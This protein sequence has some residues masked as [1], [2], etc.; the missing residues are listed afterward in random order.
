MAS[1]LSCALLLAALCWVG[2]AQQ[3]VATNPCDFDNG[4]TWVSC[5]EEAI[6]R[7]KASLSDRI[8]ASEKLQDLQVACSKY[9]LTDIHLIGA[10]EFEVIRVAYGRLTDFW[11]LTIDF[12]WT[13]TKLVMKATK[14]VSS[15]QE[16]IGLTMTINVIC[17]IPRHSETSPRFQN[18]YLCGWYEIS[19]S[20]NKDPLEINTFFNKDSLDNSNESLG[21]THWINKIVKAAVENP[22][23]IIDEIWGRTNIASVFA[24]TM[25]AWLIVHA[26]PT[27]R[28][29]ITGTI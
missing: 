17:W 4:G 18:R 8:N 28:S 1:L 14:G 21:R 3:I 26:L 11:S 27:L 15:N 25:K 6:D 24:D 10:R 22:G 9:N 16:E 19:T 23:K 2:A 29:N 5:L 20:Y 7:N 12:K 13:S